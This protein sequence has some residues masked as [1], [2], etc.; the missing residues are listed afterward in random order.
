M[1]LKEM[2]IISSYYKIGKSNDFVFVD[3]I[4]PKIPSFRNKNLDDL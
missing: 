4:T 1:P 3:I 2:Q